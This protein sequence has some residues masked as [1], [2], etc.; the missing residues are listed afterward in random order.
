MPEMSNNVHFLASFKTRKLDHEY[1]T[2]QAN[3]DLRYSP[4]YVDMG[5][6]ALRAKLLAQSHARKAKETKRP[7]HSFPLTYVNS[8]LEMVQD[9]VRHVVTVK[10]VNGNNV[11]FITQDVDQK[12]AYI[13]YLDLKWFV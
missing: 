6:L 3:K 13:F 11:V 9:S 5:S 7:V 2:D 12:Y 10:L 8:V 4:A 1:G